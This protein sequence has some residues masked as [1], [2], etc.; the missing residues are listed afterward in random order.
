MAKKGYGSGDA[1]L[2]KIANDQFAKHQLGFKG[3]EIGKSV[4]SKELG[5]KG[6]KTTRHKAKFDVV[7]DKNAWEVKTVSSQAKDIKM[8]VKKPQQIAKNKWAKENGK[9]AKSM[10]IVVND[11]IDVYVRDGVGG[12]RPVNMEKVGSYPKKR[13]KL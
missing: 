11:M 13:F 6:V 2:R 9:K 4:I 7:T 5:E 8:T 10:L 12:F 3:E 1:C